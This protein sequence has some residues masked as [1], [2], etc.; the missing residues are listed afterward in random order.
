M[1]TQAQAA[2]M[3]STA[4]KFEHVNQSLEGMLK[5]LLGELEVLQTQWVGHGGT[6]FEQVKLAWSADQETL[7][8]ALGETATAIRT[9][10]RQYQTSDSA[11]ADRLGAH[12]GGLSLPL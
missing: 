5:R 7:H 9:A 8:R 4:A 10:G 12:R 11:A 1:T 3:E 2:V 6:T